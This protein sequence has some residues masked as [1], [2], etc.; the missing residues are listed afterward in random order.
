MYVC[1]IDPY[2][3]FSYD[4]V[5]PSQH[6]YFPLTSMRGPRPCS[7]GTSTIR[8]QILT[9]QRES[10]VSCFCLCVCEDAAVRYSVRQVLGGS[11]IF[12]NV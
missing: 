2:E 4:H 5:Y 3:V 6:W 9:S 10:G 7:A 8:Q 1:V 12:V 11:C